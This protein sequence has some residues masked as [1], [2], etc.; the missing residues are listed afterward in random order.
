[1]TINLEKAVKIIDK[2]KAKAEDLEVSM[3]FAV[4]NE[5]QE[6]ISFQKMDKAPSLSVRL[7]Q[8]KAL[9]ALKLCCDTE[10]LSYLVGKKDGVLRNI[11]YD[12]A[13]SLIGGGKLILESGIITG[14]LGVSGGSEAQD[15]EVSA[16][17]MVG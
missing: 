16:A 13:V 12:N 17:A 2:A 15:I 3:S 11:R 7:S 6:L 14:A 8:A 9:T 4:F 5:E 1:M 10:S